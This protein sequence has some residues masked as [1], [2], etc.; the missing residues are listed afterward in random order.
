MDVYGG[1][2]QEEDIGIHTKAK[3][4][5]ERGTIVLIDSLILDAKAILNF[6]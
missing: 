6:V 2:I 4:S 5:H 1:H 3:E